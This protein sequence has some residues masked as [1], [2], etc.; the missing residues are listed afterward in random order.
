MPDVNYNQV[1]VPREYSRMV[2]RLRN[3]LDDTIQ[4]NDLRGVEESTDEE[5]YLAL[6]DTWDDVNFVYDPVSLQFDNISDIPW[7][8]LRMGA[9]LNVLESKGI[10]SARNTLTYNDAGGIT[11]KDS[12]EFGRYTV[13]YNTLLAEYRRRVRAWKRQKNLDGAWG[14]SHS[15]YNNSWY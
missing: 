10:S 13:W 4:Q 8:I 15:E 6:E 2:A 5:L 1:G 9:T 7:A 11:I 12:D 14:G 3:Y